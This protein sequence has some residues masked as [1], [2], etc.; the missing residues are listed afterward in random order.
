M[1]ITGKTGNV[2][3]T[4][5]HA[6]AGASES[7]WMG[8]EGCKHEGQQEMKV[9]GKAKV[10]SEPSMKESS[11]G[12]FPV[13][14]QGGSGKHKGSTPGFLSLSITGVWGQMTFCGWGAVY[15]L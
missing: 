13:E 6:T 2:V 12:I 9:H 5:P 14:A 15:V 10:H 8:T 1:R 11:K 7:G 3:S 4:V